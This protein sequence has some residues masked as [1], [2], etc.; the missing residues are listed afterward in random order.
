MGEVVL[1][2]CSRCRHFKSLCEFSP[3]S[4]GRLGNFCRA[5]HADYQAERRADPRKR[6]AA[7][8][9]TNRYRER[10]KGDLQVRVDRIKVERGCVD[11]GYDTH[12][13]ALDFDHLPGFDKAAN[14]SQLVN[15]CASWER[16]RI[17]ISKCEV[18]C[19]NCHRVR[20]KLRRP[21]RRLVSNSD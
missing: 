15:R 10:V 11:C 4:R 3:S 21:S 1:Q 17:E 18:V 7:Y 6:R 9:A 13:V 20:T 8:D 14:V 12:A 19:A 16:I 5:C 2:H